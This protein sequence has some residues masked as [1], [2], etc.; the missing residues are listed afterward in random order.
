[1]QK[2]HDDILTSRLEEIYTNGAA[3]ISWNELYLW[4]GV[5]AIAARTYRDLSTRW[6]DI[7][8][9][10]TN[11][12]GTELGNLMYVCSPGRTNAGIFVFGANM[13]MAVFDQSS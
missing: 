2:R 5:Q 6:D 4:Y 1:M 12:D 7:S 3:Y 11:A 13:P 10:W 8:T 9:E